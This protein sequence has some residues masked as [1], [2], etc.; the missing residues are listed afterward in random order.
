MGLGVNGI[1]GKFSKK[2]LK[3][4][5]AIKP[6]IGDPSCNLVFIFVI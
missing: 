6:L 5:N 1:A 4:R 2:Q 3:N